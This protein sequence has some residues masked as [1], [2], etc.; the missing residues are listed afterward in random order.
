MSR[1]ADE[2]FLSDETTGVV[3]AVERRYGPWLATFRSVNER[4]VKAQYETQIPREYLP[5]LVAALGTLGD[6]AAGE[7]LADFFQMYHADPID[8]HVVAALEQVP[9][10]QLALSGPVA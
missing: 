7:P 10:A 9:A 8:E 6:S 1:L 3:E 5:A 2:G 4:A